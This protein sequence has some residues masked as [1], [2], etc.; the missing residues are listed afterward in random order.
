MQ[1]MM[2]DIINNRPALSR[3]S[4][5]CESPRD[6]RKAIEATSTTLHSHTTHTTTDADTDA[7]RFD[8]FV[9]SKQ[10]LSARSRSR[11]RPP[12]DRVPESPYR[13]E[14]QDLM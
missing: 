9:M 13:P 11:G 1:W 6:G 5:E 3:W 14:N 2:D 10:G 8:E 7:A 12:L 4:P